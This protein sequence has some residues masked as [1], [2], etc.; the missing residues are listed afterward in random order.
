MSGY[1][2][3]AMYWWWD[4]YIEPLNLWH[5]FG[6]VSRFLEGEN[7]A[8]LGPADV[9]LGTG[10]LNALALQAEDRALVWVQNRAYTAENLQAGLENALREA[11]RSGAQLDLAWRYEPPTVTG[12]TITLTGLENG[13]YTL[14]WYDPQEGV[15]GDEQEVGVAQ[16]HLSVAI[17][18]LTRDLAFKLSRRQTQ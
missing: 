16:G 11:L 13:P 9:N 7:L 8:A 4:T 17:P 5:H 14:H 2:S 10:D 1:A 12:Q 3:T 6:G 18:P 15:W